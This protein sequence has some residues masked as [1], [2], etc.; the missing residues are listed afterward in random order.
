MQMFPRREAESG[1][2]KGKEENKRTKRHT[3]AGI[4]LLYVS[5][6]WWRAWCLRSLEAAYIY[7]L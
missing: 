3:C 7:T 4:S 5:M 1:G 2:V 6:D